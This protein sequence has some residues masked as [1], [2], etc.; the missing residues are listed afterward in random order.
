MH[1][2]QRNQA[3]SSSMNV[4]SWSSATRTIHSSSS[5]P[6]APELLDSSSAM[7]G[8]TGSS[9]GSEWFPASAQAPGRGRGG[10]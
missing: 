2:R 1:R 6:A 5:L 4:P 10:R 7:T 8:V 9:A 3:T